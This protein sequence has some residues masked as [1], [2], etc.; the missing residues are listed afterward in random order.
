MQW[1][2]LWVDVIDDEK[3]KLL[4]FEDRW[5]YVSLL[6]MKRKGILDVKETA[7]LRDRKVATKLGLGSNDCDEV[8]RRLLEVK[9]IDKNWQP[10]GWDKRQF[11]S[12]LDPTAKERK[13]K[14]RSRAR[15]GDVTRDSRAGHTAQSQI[16]ESDTDTESDRSEASI[17]LGSIRQSSS[18]KSSGEPERL[19]VGD[20]DRNRARLT[21]L[22]RS[23]VSSK[24]VPQ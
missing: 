1:L 18:L 7:S 20:P 21:A 5:H 9:L 23:M 3:L 16:T 17:P 22:T 10:L 12:D 15:H 2:R 6:C 13:Q 8:R 19:K 4:A 14:Q 24:R 11:I